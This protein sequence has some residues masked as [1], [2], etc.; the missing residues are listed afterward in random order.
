MQELDSILQKYT[1]PSPNRLK[2]AVF[3]AVDKDGTKIPLN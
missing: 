3:I 1:I 2:G